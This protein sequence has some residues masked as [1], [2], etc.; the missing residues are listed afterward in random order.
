M[1]NLELLQSAN[2]LNLLISFIIV[3]NLIVIE[4]ILFVDFSIEI[5]LKDAFRRKLFIA[6]AIHAECIQS[7]FITIIETD[8]DIWN[9]TNLIFG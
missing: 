8:I 9:V 6:V 1:E 4:H 2:I 3:R 7:L 5:D